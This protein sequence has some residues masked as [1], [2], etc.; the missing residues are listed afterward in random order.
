MTRSVAKL[1][2]QLHDER[3]VRFKAARD[4]REIAHKTTDPKAAADLWKVVGRLESVEGGG[5]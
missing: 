3:E 1:Q 4:L 2:Q 5:R